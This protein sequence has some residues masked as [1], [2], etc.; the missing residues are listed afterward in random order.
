M[1]LGFVMAQSELVHVRVGHH[2]SDARGH[3]HGDDGRPAG[4]AKR[5]HPRSPPSRGEASRV[6][7]VVLPRRVRPLSGLGSPPFTGVRRSTPSQVE[8]PT[9]F[10]ERT[11]LTLLRR[12]PQ[13][14][15]PPGPPSRPGLLFHEGPGPVSHDA[16][17]PR[18]HAPNVPRHPASPRS[19]NRA[20]EGCHRKCRSVP[21]RT[22]SK[23]FDNHVPGAST[24]GGTDVRTPSPSAMVG[25]HVEGGGIVG[26]PAALSSPRGA[27]A[28]ARKNPWSPRSPAARPSDPPPHRRR[29]GTETKGEGRS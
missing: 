22:L 2:R 19:E 6:E 20:R 8:T 1:P 23:R 14:R 9:N 26:S 24:P 27:H 16:G 7:R 15:I 11:V 5:S 21:C 25:P 17:P 29:S 18:L 10:H 28:A 13:V 4:P 3:R 12:M